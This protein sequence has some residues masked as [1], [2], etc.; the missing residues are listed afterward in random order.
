MIRIVEASSSSEDSIPAFVT[1]PHVLA[2]AALRSVPC[3][4]RTLEEERGKA[5]EANSPSLSRAFKPVTL[6]CLSSVL[7]G[8]AVGLKLIYYR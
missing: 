6:S 1:N 8:L 2:V 3:I 5:K 4:F 7:S